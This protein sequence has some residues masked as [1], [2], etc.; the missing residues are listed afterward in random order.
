MPRKRPTSVERAESAKRESKSLDFKERFDPSVKSEWPELI[1]DFVAMAN[2]GGGIIVVGVRNN[3]EATGEDLSAVLALDPA[4]IADKIAS[5]TGEHF[6]DFEVTEATRNKQRIAVIRVGAAHGAPIAFTRVGTYVTAGQEQQKVAFSKGTVYFRHG[7]KSE[8]GT[9]NDLRAFLE[10]RLEEI[11][12]QWL[13][14]IRQVVE[15]PEG[16]QVALVEAID[17]QAGVPTQ[18]RLTT[19]P[20]AVVYGKLAPDQTHPF[21][22]KE[23]IQEVNKRLG[24]ETKVNAHDILSVRRIAGITE[25]R[26]PEFTHQPRWGS[27]QYGP[28]FADWLVEEYKRDSDGPRHTDPLLDADVELD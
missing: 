11:R 9:R 14:G 2:S 10:R 3:G 5:Y 12:A 23:L 6:A 27:P 4:T 15:S 13:G 28:D 20:G 1:K 24:G 26:H 18:I 25:D 8:P 21:R 16:S 7:A 22:Q 19:D 17:E